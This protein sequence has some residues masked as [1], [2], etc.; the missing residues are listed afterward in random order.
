MM[1]HVKWLNWVCKTAAEVTQGSKSAANG[2]LCTR[3]E[4]FQ[5]MDAVAEWFRHCTEDEE[6]ACLNP[7]TLLTSVP[8]PARSM[9]SVRVPATLLITVPLPARSMDSV[10]VP[11]TLLTTVPLPVQSKDRLC[12]SASYTTDH[13]TITRAFCGQTVSL[14]GATA[15]TRT[16]LSAHSMDRDLVRLS[17]PALAAPVWLQK[18]TSIN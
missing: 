2:A 14:T 3:M 1:L 8:L 6:V 11:A 9:D 16:P 15:L 10:R 18:Q 5:E 13:C 7:T 17:T 4:A 12:H